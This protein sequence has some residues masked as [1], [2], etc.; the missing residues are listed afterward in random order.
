MNEKE[1]NQI[2]DLSD[3]SQLLGTET[4]IASTAVSKLPSAG[5]EISVNKTRIKT[6]STDEDEISEDIKP[7]IK[8]VFNK[9]RQGIK[10]RVNESYTENSG[11]SQVSKQKIK[12]RILNVERDKTMYSSVNIKEDKKVE[13]KLT[14]TKI[15]L[16]VN[17][18][19]VSK[20]LK[21]AG[22]TLKKTSKVIKS[23]SNLQNGEITA[24][25]E[26][27]KAIINSAAKKSV[28]SIRNKATVFIKKAIKKLVL[29]FSTGIFLII[30]PAIIICVCGAGIS[31]VFGGSSGKEV[32][33]QYENYCTT[34]S[35]N[36]DSKV[37]LF[38]QNNP[39]GSIICNY[40]IRGRCDW[41]AVLSLILAIFEDPSFSDEEKRL[42]SIFE[43]QNDNGIYET[44]IEKTSNGV[45]T[46]EIKNA[47]FDDYIEC[48]KKNTS[49]INSQVIDEAK[50]YYY[51]ENL[52]SDFSIDFQVKYSSN[53]NIE[54]G[55]IVSGSSVVGNAI[56][57]KALSRLGYMYVW[58]GCHSMEQIKDPNWIKFDCSGLVCWAYYQAGANIGVQ[59]TKSLSK[60][61]RKIEFSELQAGDILLYS[62]DGT[63]S[64]IH[65]V[66]IYIGGGRVVHAPQT[67]KA[68][69]TKSVES[70]KKHLY[71]CRRLY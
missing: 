59:T 12:T 50:E 20:G 17:T 40:G 53:E 1:K 11:S 67:G 2:Q 51:S 31:S 49:Y 60:M 10:T 52:L 6:V 43:K 58:G 15:R 25:K 24:D 32:I 37:S 21:K 23:T 69:T 28:R 55:T 30:I 56:A 9:K 46:L 68:I 61:G 38:E 13:V 18:G 33:N 36:Y 29:K 22:N 3:A 14:S 57:T 8:F 71:S 63:Y 62:K 35:Q 7:D 27:S 65:H 26:I 42:L 19:T 54:G 16:G 47:T 39:N 64:G 41:K 34:W 66:T 4:Q 5:V 48:L 45:K 70:D 44:H